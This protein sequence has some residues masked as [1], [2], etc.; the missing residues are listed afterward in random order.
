MIKL[1]LKNGNTIICGDGETFEHGGYLQVLDKK[2]QEIVYYDIQEWINDPEL[3]IGAFM[4]S[5][6]KSK[7]DF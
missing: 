4:N 7:K 6:L 3:V 5:C 2:G 1:P